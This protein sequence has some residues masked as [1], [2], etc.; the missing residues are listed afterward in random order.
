MRILD[1]HRT[2]DEIW[3]FEWLF[4]CCQTWS[5]ARRSQL[6]NIN[7]T[8]T[9][10]PDPSESNYH[11][12]FE[13]FELLPNVQRIELIDS[14]PCVLTCSFDVSLFIYCLFRFV[15]LTQTVYW[16]RCS[17]TSTVLWKSA[18]RILLKLSLGL[19][20]LVYRQSPSR[21]HLSA[22]FPVRHHG[23]TITE[24]FQILEYNLH[25]PSKTR[26]DASVHS[27]PPKR[28]KCFAMAMR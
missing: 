6:K 3:L 20:H 28:R 9:I 15:G 7:V 27:H 24:P 1:T 10:A 26:I 21:F 5:L 8:V 18:V 19:H 14:Q 22:V 2:Q 13:V 17:V 23:T 25:L 12:Q 11:D 16:I 4:S